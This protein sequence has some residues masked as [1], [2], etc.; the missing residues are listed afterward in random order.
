MYTHTHTHTDQREC[1]ADSDR[2]VSDSRGLASVG[3][4]ALLTHLA[5]RLE[6]MGDGADVTAAAVVRVLAVAHVG[7]ARHR[8]K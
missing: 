6:V 2:S 7:S 1:S 4:L 3:R 5:R 8:D